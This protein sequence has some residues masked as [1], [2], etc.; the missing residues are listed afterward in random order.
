MSDHRV[1]SSGVGTARPA[2]PA[3]LWHRQSKLDTQMYHER[4]CSPPGQE[5]I[6]GC[7]ATEDPGERVLREQQRHPNLTEKLP[8]TAS[9]NV[10]VSTALFV[11]SLSLS[12]FLGLPF[13]LLDLTLLERGGKG[14]VCHGSVPGFFSSRT[15][16][17]L[18]WSNSIEDLEL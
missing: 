12:F 4:H 18:T 16:S 1:N 15:S 11:P 2:A 5:T 14:G 13:S 3:Q 9:R 7:E 6:Y 17:S 10:F 8:A